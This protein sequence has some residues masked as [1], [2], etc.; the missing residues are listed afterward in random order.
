MSSLETQSLVPGVEKLFRGI[1]NPSLTLILKNL[2]Y[3]NELNFFVQSINICTTLPGL[4]IFPTHHSRNGQ[5]Q[6]F[7]LPNGS[8]SVQDILFQAG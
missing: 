1:L 4:L 6:F 8:G 3:N 5:A 7:L 2:N